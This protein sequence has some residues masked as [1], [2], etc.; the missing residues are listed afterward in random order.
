MPSYRV[1]R[2]ILRFSPMVRILSLS[3]SSTVSP[4]SSLQPSSASTSAG[5]CASMAPATL[6]TNSLNI[7]F[8]A[9][10]SVSEFTSTITPILASLSLMAYTTP[11]AATRSAFLAAAAKP[12]SRS[13]ATARSK[14]PSA[15]VRAFLQSIIPTPVCW[16]SL[17][18]SW[19]VKAIFIS[20]RC[21]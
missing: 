20:S 3:A 11:S 2:R 5:L 15:S 14:S 10:K 4:E 6:V 17:F 12:F 9:T 21:C 13:S 7:S 19:A 18:T 16:R 8:L 1:K